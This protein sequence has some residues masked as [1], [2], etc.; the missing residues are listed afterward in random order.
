[1]VKRHDRERERN[2]FLN[3]SH[4]SIIKQGFRNDPEEEKTLWTAENTGSGRDGSK[5]RTD[6]KRLLVIDPNRALG[7]Q[8]RKE[9]K[10]YGLREKS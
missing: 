2:G 1:M 6:G 3:P 7:P 4:G 8:R 9:K 5:G 10:R